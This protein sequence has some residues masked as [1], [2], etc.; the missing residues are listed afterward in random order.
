[1]PSKMTGEEVTVWQQLLSEALPRGASRA[2]GNS[3]VE[4]DCVA[5]CW[6]FRASALSLTVSMTRPKG[7][8]EASKVGGAWLQVAVTLLVLTAL[9]KIWKERRPGGGLLTPD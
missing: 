5:S 4:V 7:E 8:W 9:R 2:G 1:M 3:G 6:A